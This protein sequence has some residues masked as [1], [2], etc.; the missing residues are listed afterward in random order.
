VPD[1]TA[2]PHVPENSIR[3]YF[4]PPYLAL[5]Q[6]SA[7]YLHQRY[8]LYIIQTNVD[9]KDYEATS[10]TSSIQNVLRDNLDPDTTQHRLVFFRMFVLLFI[11]IRGLNCFFSIFVCLLAW[12]T[13]MKLY[14][15]T[16]LGWDGHFF[17]F[18]LNV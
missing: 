15:V 16:I 4:R 11:I 10:T 12:H 2:A 3:S 5:D 14:V 17:R 18:L 13:V 1:T 8:N 7:D 6:L 9:T